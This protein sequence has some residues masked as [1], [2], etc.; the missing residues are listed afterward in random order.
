MTR[1]CSSLGTGTSGLSGWRRARFLGAVVG[2]LGHALMPLIGNTADAHKSLTAFPH[3]RPDPW[4]HQ[5]D[6]RRQIQSRCRAIG[7]GCL[8]CREMV[9]KRRGRCERPNIV[10]AGM[11]DELKRLPETGSP[12]STRTARRRA[13]SGH[14]AGL[15]DGGAIEICLL[16]KFFGAGIDFSGMPATG[17]NIAGCG[18]NMC[19]VIDDVD[20]G[21]TE[22]PS[23]NRYLVADSGGSKGAARRTSKAN[24]PRPAQRLTRSYV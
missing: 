11:R 6:A 19:V 14:F 23:R 20:Q 16:Q 3:L 21:Q 15:P 8:C 9:E 18:A 4:P 7:Y 22:I 1:T 12:F 24:G 10:S 2:K 13:S 5:G 17:K